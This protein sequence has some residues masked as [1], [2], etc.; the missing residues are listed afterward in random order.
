MFPPEPI[1]HPQGLQA[2]SNIQ[3]PP[4]SNPNWLFEPRHVIAAYLSLLQACL[5][6]VPNVLLEPMAIPVFACTSIARWIILLDRGD[7]DDRD[8]TGAIQ[9][10][11]ALKLYPT[12][13]ARIASIGSSH[14]FPKSRTE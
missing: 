12:F 4:F 13:D 6:S 14:A 2:T 3:P 11:A 9:R 7:R 5:A 10:F 1:A 8:D